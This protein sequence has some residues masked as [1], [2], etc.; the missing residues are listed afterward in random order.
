M[1]HVRMI[2]IAAVLTIP[3]AAVFGQ[4]EAPK[5]MQQPMNPACQA[6]MQQMQT[7]QQQ[8]KTMDDRLDKLVAGMNAASGPERVDA[9]A[10]VIN[11]LVNQRKQMETM[12]PAMM[13]HMTEH[14]QAGMKG[15]SMANCP[16]MKQH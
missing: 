14:M 7:M 11:E 9:M 2:L 1:R 5:P 4:T 15:D 6:M 10:A 13:Q 3:S 16:M 12:M 8:M